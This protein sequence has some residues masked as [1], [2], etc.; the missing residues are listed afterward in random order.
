MSTSLSRQLEQL[1]A[2]QPTTVTTSWTTSGVFS[3]GPFILD[4]VDQLD[5]KQLEVLAMDSFD[6]LERENVLLSQFGSKIFD[7]E[8]QFEKME[9]DSDPQMDWDWQEQFL[10]CLTPNV[11]DRKAQVIC[12][13]IVQKV[14]NYENNV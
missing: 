11:L 2:S 12:W 9:T 3:S 13:K 7:V 14:L 4:Q 5:A 6:K 1:K 10:Y 8:D